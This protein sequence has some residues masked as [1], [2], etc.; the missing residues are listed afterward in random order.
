MPTRASRLVPIGDPTMERDATLPPTAADLFRRWATGLGI[1]A[2]LVSIFLH[3]GGGVLSYF[4]RFGGSGIGAPAP[5]GEGLVEMALGT[6]AELS[7]LS[8]A[9]TGGSLPAVP[10]EASTQPAQ[11]PLVTEG[12]TETSSLSAGGIGE[13]GNLAGGGDV[14][15]GG[16]GTG[17]WGLGGTGG[18]GTSFFGVEAGGTRFA[19]V[20]DAS[21]SMAGK[22][23]V[24]LKNE[25]RAT[26]EGLQPDAQVCVV[27]FSD[28]AKPLRKRI[29]W[30]EATAASKRDM[31]AEV[32]ALQD[33]DLGPNTLVLPG[34][35]LVFGQLRPRPD[36]IFLM[37]DGEFLDMVASVPDEINLLNRGQER[38]VPVHTICFGDPRGEE[39][40]KRIAKNSGGTY[41][42][43]P[44]D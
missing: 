12:L 5:A 7:E 6:G 38:P 20:L 22:R 14:D 30:V 24:R 42:F 19:F 32:D 2:I 33:L 4:I 26:I 28:V 36:A 39:G 10:E 21:G 17:G 3:T 34:M 29:G 40:M 13:V 16:S 41:T 9:S 35:R 1:V 23:L 15:V 25:L 31:V 8:A 43:V 18:N 27:L 37:T 44:A 11:M